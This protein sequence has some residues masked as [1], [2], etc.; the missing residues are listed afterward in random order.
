M[1]EGETPR[2]PEGFRGELD[3]DDCGTGSREAAMASMHLSLG[4]IFINP[5]AEY[6]MTSP[7]TG[8]NERRTSFENFMLPRRS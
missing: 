4:L 7:M 6:G 2:L 5:P 1:T 3:K 8:P